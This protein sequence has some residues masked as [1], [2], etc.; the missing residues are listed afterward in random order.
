MDKSTLSETVTVSQGQLRGT[1]LP[2]AGAIAWLG[3]PYAK[4]PVGEL[5]WKAP[6][7]ADP[8]RG[9]RSAREYGPSS[10]QRGPEGILGSEDCLYINLWRPDHEQSGLP[11][12]VYLHGGGNIGGSGRDF[13]GAGLARATNS[14]I[15]TV[16]YRLGVM[17]FFR[18]PALRT[19]D[20][21]DD[22][23]NYGL[24]DV[25]Q[26]LRWVQANIA[27][28]GGDPGKVTLGGQ[29]AGGR[30]ALAAYL[31]PLGRGLFQQL[32][33]L[34]GG[35]TTADCELGEAK[36]RVI[37]TDLAIKAGAAA[38]EAQDWQSEQ[39]A[40]VLAEWLYRQEAADFVEAIPDTGLRMSAF[41]H[42]FEDGVV[43]PSG[44]FAALGD[45][46]PPLPIVLGS[47]ATEFS[48]FAL[49]AP[50]FATLAQGSDSP[51]E[52][53]RRAYEAAVQY[54]SE[55]YAAFNVEEVAERFLRA[56]PDMAIF[57]YRFSWGLRDGVTE[58]H[59]R[60]L[61]GAAHGADL[62]FYTGDF[63]EVMQSFPG[64]VITAANEPGRMALISCMRG[65][66]RHFLHTGDPNGEALPPWTPWSGDRGTA[67]I[68]RLDATAREA[69]VHMDKKLVREDILARLEADERLQP[70]R[71]QGLRAELFAG[72]FFWTKR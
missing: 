46:G 1:R 12:L 9:I 8:W 41:P 51:E 11:V 33:I 64:A 62:P 49:A 27:A 37:V 54:G 66:L 31:S 53:Q 43:I 5:R 70:D 69:V 30:N 44:G 34:S 58:L 4:P 65:Y 36:A 23:G 21:L 24:L 48:G 3:V 19:G 7:D 16:N 2:E 60:F 61:L 47:T 18:H 40:E 35:M 55:L 72:R 57:G 25:I 14:I 29:S 67:R 56:N 50:R 39:S 10:M 59:Y 45:S 17:G 6:R 42:L 32:F 28:F 22:S 13:Q 68:L 20:P 52:Q 63:S 71:L 15:V 26:A 38:A